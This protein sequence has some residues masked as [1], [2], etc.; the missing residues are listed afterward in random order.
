MAKS[1]KLKPNLSSCVLVR[2]IADKE[3]FLSENCY[4]LHSLASLH[5]V[6]ALDLKYLLIAGEMVY[7]NWLSNKVTCSANKAHPF[8]LK[9]TPSGKSS[10]SLPADITAV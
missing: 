4:M 8:S 6:S 7:K 10:L 3:A 2:T 5:L 9:C 1:E